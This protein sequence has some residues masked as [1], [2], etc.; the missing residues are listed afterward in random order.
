MFWVIS[1]VSSLINIII[2]QLCLLTY[3]RP[4][5]LSGDGPFPG[6]IDLFGSAGGL[7][8]YRSA[9]LASRGIASFALAFFAYD[10]LPKTLGEFHISYFEEAVQFLLKHEKVNL[11]FSNLIEFVV[12]C[13]FICIIDVF[14]VSTRNYILYES[15][16][17]YGIIYLRNCFN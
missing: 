11:K 16:G 8:E 3:L 14:F 17:L 15:S 6:V 13:N 10:D 5:L 4:C 12:F 1:T 2:L 7:L 9:Q